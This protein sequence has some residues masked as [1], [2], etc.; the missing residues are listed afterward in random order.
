MTHKSQIVLI[1]RRLYLYN[2]SVTHSLSPSGTVSSFLWQN[3]LSLVLQIFL[4]LAVFE[5]KNVG[6]T[7]FYNIKWINRLDKQK[8]INTTAKSFLLSQ[9]WVTKVD[10]LFQI[11]SHFNL[12]SNKPLFLHVCCTSRLKTLGEKGKML[13]IFTL[14]KRSPCFYVSA[15]QNF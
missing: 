6:K 12:F 7:A 15:A 4:Y 11:H 9:L 5:C 8:V 2:C 1:W 10:R 13:V 3:V 14:S